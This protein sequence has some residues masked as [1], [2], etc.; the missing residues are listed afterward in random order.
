MSQEGR[1]LR[2]EAVV[3]WPMTECMGTSPSLVRIEITA[4]DLA[5]AAEAAEKI[6]G[7][8]LSSP[9]PPRR[10]PGEGG[11]RVRVHADTS[12]VPSEGG[13]LESER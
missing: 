1:T 3:S 10:I 7:L 8:W 9:S 13:Y 5:T 2:R 12:R 6:A 11:V 4:A